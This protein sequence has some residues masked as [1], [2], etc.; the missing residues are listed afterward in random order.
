MLGG[1]VLAG[2]ARIETTAEAPLLI[3]SELVQL[4]R[5]TDYEVR[6]ERLEAERAALV[7]GLTPTNISFEQFLTSLVAQAIFPGDPGRS[8]QRTLHER[9]LAAD[10]ADETVE[11]DRL[12]AAEVAAYRKNID[13]MERI[14]RLN[15]NLELLKSHLARRDAADGAPLD[16]EIG[17][18]RVGDFRLVTFPGELVSGVGLDVKQAAGHPTAFVA[19]YTNGYLHYLPT[20]RQRANT[21]YAQEDCDCLVAPEWEQVF[22]DVAARMFLTLGAE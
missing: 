2:L 17:G 10:D 3:A 6:I 20:A 14:T 22:R 9:G 16:A 12:L 19:G 4:P 1:T 7:A 5:G 11:H 8:R 18:L 21:G 13:A 15:V